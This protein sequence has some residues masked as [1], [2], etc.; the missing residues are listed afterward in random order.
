MLCFQPY[1]FVVNICVG[2]NIVLCMQIFGACYFS[3]SS[4]AVFQLARQVRDNSTGE[5][6]LSQSLISIH[7]LITLNTFIIHLP[8]VMNYSTLAFLHENRERERDMRDAPLSSSQFLS[9]LLLSPSS[10][11]SLP[12]AALPPLRRERE[13][14]WGGEAAL[15][16]HHPHV[17]CRA[18]METRFSFPFPSNMS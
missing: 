4:R 9:S 3:C 14:R 5:A 17:Y 13:R 10:S 8:R 6:L 1:P 2:C 7:P 15:K 18:V 16:M 12:H 11:I